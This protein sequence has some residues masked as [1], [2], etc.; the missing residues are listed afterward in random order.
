MA[1][2]QPRIKLQFEGILGE[3]LVEH[4]LQKCWYLNPTPAFGFR[5]FAN[6]SKNT[7]ELS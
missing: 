1:A 7:L 3:Q 2:A 6:L 5:R 4:N